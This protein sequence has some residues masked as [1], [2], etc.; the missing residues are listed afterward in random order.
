MDQLVRVIARRSLRSERRQCLTKLL[1]ELGAPFARAGAIER[2]LPAD[3]QHEAAEPL[4][5][6]HAA[7]PQ[8]LDQQ[9]EDVVGKVFGGLDASQAPASERA[10]RRRKTLTQGRL[11]LPIAISGALDQF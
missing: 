8:R 4:G 3:A 10:N 6:L 1:P 7:T 2:E 9:Q 5:F 11:S